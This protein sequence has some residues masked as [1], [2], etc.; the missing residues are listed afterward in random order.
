[1]VGQVTM[2]ICLEKGGGDICPRGSRDVSV[3]LSVNQSC[4]RIYSLM[5]AKHDTCPLHIFNILVPMRLRILQKLG[6][7]ILAFSFFLASLLFY[8]VFMSFS[9]AE[10]LRNGTENLNYHTDASDTDSCR[11]FA[12]PPPPH[13]VPTI[14]RINNLQISKHL[15]HVFPS[16]FT[17][18][19]IY[20]K[21]L[22]CTGCPMAKHVE[23]VFN[24]LNSSEF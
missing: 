2:H 23:Q 18:P 8:C 7:L 15:C 12:T 22:L 17:N 1:M 19:I 11:F 10:C 6:K 14:P 24:L 20:L 5:S 21:M 4:L 9:F 13:P 3:C 16:I